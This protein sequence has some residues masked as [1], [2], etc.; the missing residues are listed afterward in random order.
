[1]HVEALD[2][3]Y[4]A[5]RIAGPVDRA[6]EVGSRN[7]NASARE[8]WVA[9]WTGLDIKPGPNI[10]IV[11]DVTEPVDGKWDLV[12]ST[13][14]LEHC[15]HPRLA[16]HHM[17]E[18]STCWVLVTCATDGRPEHNATDGGPLPDGEYYRN[19]SPAELDHPQF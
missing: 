14:M 5:S 1:M 10:D 17:V 16:L 6:V 13:E 15:T 8:F 19:V 2:F 9:T 7:V 3:C 4:R 11:A 18:A 12:L